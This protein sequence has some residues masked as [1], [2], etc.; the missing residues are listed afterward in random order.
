M[1]KKNIVFIL[2]DDHGQ[3]AMGAYKNKSIITPTLDELAKE[4]VKFDNFFCTSPVCS[5]SRASILTGKIPSQ[6]GVH[7]WIGGGNIS[8]EMVQETKLNLKDYLKSTNK[9]NRERMLGKR[10]LEDI[11]DTEVIRLLDTF[12]G[13]KYRKYEIT[14]IR[15][16][17]DT[18]TYTEVLKKNGYNCGI[19][20][21]WHLGDSA[22][23]QCGLDYWKVIS[24]GGTPY[25]FSDYVINGKIVYKKDYITNIITDDAINFIEKSVKDTKPFYINI[26]YTAPHDP[27]EENDQ[28]KEVYDLYKNHQ[29]E[30]IEFQKVHEWQA[31]KRYIGD[32]LEK[33]N[34]YLRGY[35]SAVTSMD[36]NIKKVINKLKKLAIYE[37]TII[38]YTSDNG[39]N[40]GQHGIWGKGN[41]TFPINMYDTSVKVPF[42]YFD[43]S[44]SFKGKVSDEMVSQYDIFPTILD[45]ANIPFEY[46]ESFPGKSIKK[47]LEG[48]SKTLRN[49]YIYDEYG[50]VRMVRNKKFKYIHRYPYGPFEFYDLQLDPTEKNNEY[51]NI[52]YSE[53][54]NRMRNELEEWFVN[55]V[56]PDIDGATLP[57]TGE[58]QMTKANRSKLKSYSFIQ[59]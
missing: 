47:L 33:R 4:G 51:N 9:S 18:L 17:E 12:E 24:G 13:Q 52:M 35:Y 44:S 45:L 14:P 21:K 42:I 57:V 5:P 55:Y 54:I 46:D 19:V 53:T 7:D 22:N 49:I 59:D 16:M 10:K 23:A 48:N 37:D 15:Y 28:E 26:N 30:D 25:T 50:P 8:K 56:N 6:H 36:R 27:W 40:L 29:F 11:E 34:Y 41:G 32:T 20:G 43:P 2:S 1:K 38:I 31:K 39:L 3:W 58:G